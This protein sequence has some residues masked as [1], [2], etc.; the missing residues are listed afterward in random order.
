VTRGWPW[1]APFALQVVALLF[2]ALLTAQ[3]M[4]VALVL[5]TPPPRPTFYH[6]PEVAEALGG[7]P[8]AAGAEAGRPRGAQPRLVRTV[9][10]EPRPLAKADREAAEA[11]RRALARLL[12][13]P[14]DR[15]Y[16]QESGPPF[17]YWLRRGAGIRERPAREG[18]RPAADLAEEE[19]DGPAPRSRPGGFER[20][21]VGGFTAALRQADGRWAVVRPPP[22]PFPS[23]WQKRILAWLAGCIL[24]VAPAGYLF[25]RRITAPLRAFAQAAERLGR[26]PRAPLMP[27]SGPAEIGV[28]AQ[29]FNE[30][31]G[32]L[33]RYVEDR[34]AMVGAISH[35]MRTPLARMR[36][37]LEAAPPA[38]KAQVLADVEQMEGM[39]TAVLSFIRDA[40]EARD[41]TRLDLL[42]VLEVAVD[43][44][45]LL[46]GDARIDTG[47]PLI[48]EADALALQRLFANLVDNAVKYGGQARIRLFEENGEAVTQV[49]DA[50]PGLEPGDL[51]RVFAPFYRAEAA[52]T[53]DGGVGLG[54]AVARS[55]AR[56]HGGD[57]TL[58]NGQGGL[59]ATVRLPMPMAAEG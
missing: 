41:R 8:S 4:T 44:V 19:E 24:V 42:S 54:L 23:P 14:P 55:I 38:V 46:G 36:F 22:E 47:H 49:A 30:M 52:R 3:L 11:G 33:T 18:P 31:Q 26:D 9:E 57:V 39:I 27:L 43:D 58:A 37:K 29:A 7:H 28:A 10:G 56:A 25:A 32:R 59:T 20:P 50:G 21:V 35:D 51:E 48:V 40:S 5:L 17:P 2:L 34:T 1:R 6:L 12:N 53:L 13:V 45:S 16:L 15:V